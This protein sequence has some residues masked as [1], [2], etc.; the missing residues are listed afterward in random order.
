MCLHAFITWNN[1][2]ICLHLHVRITSL[3]SVCEC[4]TERR[5][6]ALK[7]PV[8][9][10]SHENVSI[11]TIFSPVVLLRRLTHLIPSTMLMCRYLICHFHQINFQESTFG[12]SHLKTRFTTH[13]QRCGLAV[14][15]PGLWRLPSVMKSLSLS[16]SSVMDFSLCDH[17][18]SVWNGSSGRDSLSLLILALM[19]TPDTFRLFWILLSE[20]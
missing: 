9:S 15:H 8:V 6:H 1:V 12:T 4:K 16:C 19:Q 5:W 7:L 2:I 11:W 3:L 18:V 10:C 13:L 20:L 17:W 14:L